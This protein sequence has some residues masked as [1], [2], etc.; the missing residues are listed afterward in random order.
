[1]RGEDADREDKSALGFE[2]AP[3]MKSRRE[4]ELATRKSD[5]ALL[6]ILYKSKFG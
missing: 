6:Q 1:M 5:K 4:Q 2:R 3:V